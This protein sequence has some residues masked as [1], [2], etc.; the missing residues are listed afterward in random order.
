MIIGFA[1]VT[2]QGEIPASIAFRG[3]SPH[4]HDESFSGM[5]FRSDLSVE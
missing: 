1:E 4:N 5:L 3:K 2:G